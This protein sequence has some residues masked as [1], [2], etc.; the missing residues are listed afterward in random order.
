MKV[1]VHLLS[2]LA[3]FILSYL[4]MVYGW[5]LEVRSWVWIAGT[6]FGA[7]FIMIVQKAIE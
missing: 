7:V 4:G 5:G 3:L 2:I 6:W 1:L